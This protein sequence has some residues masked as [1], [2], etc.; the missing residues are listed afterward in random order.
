MTFAKTIERWLKRDLSGLAAG[1][2]STSTTR[3]RVTGAPPRKG[4]LG[5]VDL[6]DLTAHHAPLIDRIRVA[7]AGAE[8]SFD[9]QVAPLIQR[10]AA[11]VHLL[12]ATRDGH[13]RDPAGCL[14]CGLEVGLHALQAAD[15]Q[16]F[17]ARGTVPERRAAAPRWRA[18]ALAMGLCSEVH[19]PV[20]GAVVRDEQDAQWNP[21]LMPLFDWLRQGGRERYRIEWSQTGAPPR[22]ATLAILPQILGPSLI[23]F[24][25]DPDRTILDHMVA[26]IAAP[27]GAEPNALGALVEQTLSR[28][29]ARDLRRAPI[30]RPALPTGEAAEPPPS[31]EPLYRG[32]AVAPSAV[33]TGSES[34]AS[35]HD[36]ATP[37]PGRAR[38]ADEALQG[39]IT[40][41]AAEASAPVAGPQAAEGSPRRRLAVPATL[42]PV[43]AEALLSLLSP[44]S[45]G[46]LPAGV[47]ISD[48]G[49]YVPLGV[50]EARGLDTGLVVRTL[51]DARL[52]VLQGARKVWRKR[53]GDEDVAGLML[54]VRLLA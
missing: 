24:L 33:E 40:L 22:S 37:D 30:Q 49:I 20:F 43:V 8:C 1:S 44:S 9:V 35:P 46:A 41:R 45:G 12:P 42:N 19:R 17:S 25:A 4:E 52:L 13:F 29:V 5:A 3:G 31:E 21:L 26:A 10:F 28:V 27:P 50:W 51:H 23:G 34:I 2:L 6:D 48:E 7:Y 36:L 39:E 16:I 53:C 32:G 11:F 14:H 18:A 38:S 54:H 47:E 15:G